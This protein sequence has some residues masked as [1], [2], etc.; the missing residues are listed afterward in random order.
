MVVAFGAAFAIASD[1]GVSPMAA[2]PYVLALITPL[3]I[4]LLSTLMFLVFILLQ[5]LILGK[6][7]KWFDLVQII[8]AFVF[9]FFLEFAIF[10]LG[11]LQFPGYVGRLGMLAISIFLIALGLVLILSAQIIALPPEALCVAAEKRWPRLKFH[12]AK[13]SLDSALVLLALSASLIFLCDLYG[14]REG[15]IISAIA[16]GRIIPLVK[17]LLNPLL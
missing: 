16:I 14:V 4:G 3:Y 2:L 13:I 17:K 11:D 12:I 1:L 15:T 6:K 9:G 7:F 10:A 5:I 8:F